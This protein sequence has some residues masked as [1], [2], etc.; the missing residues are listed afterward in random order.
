MEGR[1]YFTRNQDLPENRQEHIF[2]FETF[3]FRFV[4]DNGV[5]SKTRVD[6]GTRILLETLQYEAL[7]GNVLDLG[8]GYGPVAIVLKKLFSTVVMTGADINPRAV[9][10]ARKNAA[11]N[12]VEVTFR[13]SDAFSDIPETADIIVTN[14]PIRAGKTVIYNM[15]TQA[16][17]HLADKGALYVVMRKKQGAESALRFLRELFGNG[18]CINRKRGYWVLKCTR[19]IDDSVCQC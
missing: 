18:T 4:T 17:M 5:F 10:L 6:E 1:H 9:E 7:N 3:R 19:D 11:L 13:L 14:P 16:K 12:D 15:F 8:C 2:L